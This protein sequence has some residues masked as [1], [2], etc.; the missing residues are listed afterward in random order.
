MTGRSLWS[1]LMLAW[2]SATSAPSLPE[3]PLPFDVLL[4]GQESGGESTI[5][6][7]ADGMDGPIATAT[8]G[9]SSKSAV[10]SSR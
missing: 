8:P 10:K 7:D 1:A 6:A 3:G 4:S 5:L 2:L 9:E